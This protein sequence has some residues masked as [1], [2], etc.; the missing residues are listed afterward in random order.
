VL[1]LFGKV[2]GPS[3]A[4]RGAGGPDRATGWDA[5]GAGAVDSDRLRAAV[6]K[7]TADGGTVV[8]VAV[9]GHK[10][11]LCLMAVHADWVGLRR[12]QTEIA[13]AGVLI[14]DSYN[15]VT[16][17]SEYAVDTPENERRLRL[18]P[19]LPPKDKHAWCFYPM[20]KRRNVGANW[21]T[22]PYEERR[23]L[24]RE[25][26]MSGRKFGGRIAQLV[27]GST[28]LDDY[29]WGVTLWAE[30]VDDLKAVVYTLRYDT[31]SAVY[32]EFGSFYVGVT[33]TLDDVFEQL[34]L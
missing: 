3:A 15:S 13:R 31:G 2:H 9:L 33:G 17:L 5:A 22:L 4:S 12:L 34:D 27:T 7:L 30:H 19:K 25:H 21:F 24:M 8:P 18:F 29:E 6:E 26:G 14:V 16:E 28:G 20:S 32:G 23:G 10:A 1:H 11:D